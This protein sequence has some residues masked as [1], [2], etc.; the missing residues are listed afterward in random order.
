M[1]APEDA[2]LAYAQMRRYAEDLA[3]AVEGMKHAMDSLEEA[4]LDTVHRLALAVEYKDEETG[5]HVVR[6]SRYTEL[7][8]QA[9]GLDEAFCRRALFAAPMHDVGK[10][11][12]PDSI[13]LKPG[14]LTTE[15]FAV[16]KTHP[17][18]GARILARSRSP[19]IRMA[20]AIAATHHEKYDGSGYPHGTAGRAIPIEGRLVAIAD[21]FDA[22]TTRR[23]YKEAFSVAKSLDIMREGRGVH[24]DPLLLDCFFDVMDQVL[25]VKAEVES[26]PDGALADYAC[27]TWR[28]HCECEERLTASLEGEL[29]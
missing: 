7:L 6:L 1:P 3:Y 25:D 27:A 12:I 29:P 24:F 8:A 15:E 5:A 2:S 13:L 11:G 22:L 28:L 20:E 10:I 9:W 16:M 26:T 23:P 18:I 14:P 21:V 17:V 19:I 4:Y